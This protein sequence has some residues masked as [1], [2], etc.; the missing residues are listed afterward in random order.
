MIVVK[1]GDGAFNFVLAGAHTSAEGN[2][3][4]S[5]RSVNPSTPSYTPG[6]FYGTSNGTTQVV[7][8]AEP[9]AGNYAVLDNFSY[10]NSDT[11]NQLISVRVGTALIY[12]TNLAPGE[13]VEFAE[14]SG[15]NVY[16]SN[17]ALKVSQTNGVNVLSTGIQIA[18]LAADVTNNNA[19]ANTIADVTGLSF[20]VT[21]GTLYR[22]RFFIRYT[23]A[24]TT[25][26]SRWSITGPGSPTLLT[27][28]SQ[29]SL[30]T[31]SMTTNE[32]LT[33]YDTPSG[34]NASSAATGGNIAIVEGFIRP[35]AN[36]TVTA[37][38][39]SEI[40][41]SA[42]IARAGSYVEYQALA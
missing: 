3:S 2:A 37:R 23:A 14:G 35:S 25:T 24:A 13:R 29:Y 19:T 34:A 8:I 21:E 9:T 10:Y 27:Y 6:S 7:V 11:G 16:M 42:I 30:T 32:G 40:A 39:A 41:S 17:G 22:F 28:R 4:A 18:R 20:A 38:F 33:A 12:T 36:G 5:W 15:W 26:G 1:N 31:T